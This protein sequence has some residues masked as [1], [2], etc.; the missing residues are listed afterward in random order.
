M[1]QD[2]AE[3]IRRALVA[4]RAEQFRFL[5][6]L[7]RWPSPNPPGDTSAHADFVA[8][9]LQAMDLAVEAVPVPE[10]LTERAGVPGITNLVVRHEFGDGPTVVLNAHADTPPAGEGW[11]HDPFD[12]RVE[13][14]AIHGLGCQASKANVAAFAFAL[15]ALKESAVP[16]AGAVELHITYDGNTGGHFGPFW[17]LENRDRKPDVAVVGGYARGVVT[18]HVGCL[19]VEVDIRADPGR[20]AM[21]AAARVMEAAY[22]M[23]RELEEMRSGILGLGRPTVAVTRLA[24]EG[25]GQALADSARLRLWRT[26]LPGENVDEVKQHVTSVL[27]RALIGISGVRCTARPAGVDQPFQPVPGSRPWTRVFLDAATA[28]SGEEMRVRGLPFVTDARH[29]TAHGIPTVIYGGGSRAYIRDRERTPGQ[30]LALDDLRLGTEVTALAVA[31]F[32]G[33]G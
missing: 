7:I 8:G 20:D 31:S 29:Y 30:V 18:H 19:H 17:L 15:Q 16:L 3:R 23:T 25:A 21:Y 10:E 5:G 6:E 14:G 4:R 26:T 32:L 1:D 33:P 11:R 28:V 12:P 13:Q 27:T 2:V 22:G 9:W 24:G